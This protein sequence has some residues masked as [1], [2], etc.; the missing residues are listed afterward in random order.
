MSG[1]GFDTVLV[2]D[3]GAQYAQLIAR[4]VRECEVYSEIV[5]SSITAAEVAAR[6]PAGLILSGG[7][8]SVHVEGAPSLDLA[9]YR[10]GVPVLG[11]CYGAQLIAEQLGGSVG[12]NQR[13]EYGRAEMTL[14]SDNGSVLLAGLPSPQPVWMS[15]F[16]AIVKPP[17]G[18]VVTAS[19]EASPVA[20]FEDVERGRYGVQFHPE[21]EHTAHGR[22]VM[23]RFLRQ[24]CGA[25]PNWSM[26]SIIDAAVAAVSS[27]VGEGRAI[28]GLSGGVDSAVAAALL[29]VRTLSM[30]LA[31]TDVEQHRHFATAAETYRRDLMRRMNGD[32]AE[33]SRS[34]DF[35]YAAG[36]DL[37]AEVPPLQ[38]DAP[39]LG[40]VLNNRILSLLVLGLWLA[41]AVLAASASV[42]RAEV[43]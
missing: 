21:V 30:G 13:G 20:A 34:G 43:A 6:Q 27:Q 39:T 5:P 17:P 10:S 2:V 42:R 40:W 29:A 25:G 35:S 4:R 31:G 37:W 8:A 41:G 9:I 1:D 15:H 28:C 23:E 22:Q 36:P 7:P 3:F 18:A 24:A 11:I 33:N 38:Y 14:A 19:T 16:D 26:V 12:P 32:L